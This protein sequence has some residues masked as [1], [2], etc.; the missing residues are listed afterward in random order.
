[1]WNIEQIQELIWSVLYY[2]RFEKRTILDKILSN[3]SYRIIITDIK[4]LLTVGNVK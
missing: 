2:N 4:Y 1:M 3:F